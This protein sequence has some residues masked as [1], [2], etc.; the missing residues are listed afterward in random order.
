MQK[1]T[2]LTQYI[3]HCQRFRWT[4]N[5]YNGDYGGTRTDGSNKIGVAP[6]AKWITVR[7]FDNA[8]SLQ[9]KFY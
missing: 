9:I 3:S 5:P 8:G 6:G 2:G 4:W 7:V 1:E